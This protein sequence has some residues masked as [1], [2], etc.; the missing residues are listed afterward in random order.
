MSQLDDFLT[1]TLARQL[2]AEQALISGDPGP[3]LAMWSTQEPVTVFGAEKSVIGAEEA[4]G[5]FRW[6]ATRFSNCTDYRFELVAAGASGDLAYTLGYERFSFSMDGGPVAPITLRVT[7]LYRREDGEWKIVHRH[8][9]TLMADQTA[10]A[11][12]PAPAGE[13]QREASPP[14]AGRRSTSRPEQAERLGPART[15]AAAETDLADF[16]ATALPRQVETE[17]AWHQRDLDARL[18]LWS[19]REPVTLFGG[20]GA[21]VS[22][23]D[24]VRRNFRTAVTGIV[25]CRSFDYDLVAA[26]GGGELAY[27]VGYE[28][29]SFDPGPVQDYT[30]RV[31]YLYRRENGEWKIVHRHADVPPTGQPLRAG[32]ST[33]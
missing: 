19:T 33:E 12:A 17:S 13:R 28:H 25:P 24:E 32:A 14:P 2:D 1:P 29:I 4:R 9:D 27:T 30:L 20:G 22:S 7:H 10:P 11:E 5:A 23:S 26:G 31:T 8:A 16:L 3:R 6:L 21:C 18:A 15:L